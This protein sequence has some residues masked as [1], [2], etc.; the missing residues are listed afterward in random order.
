MILGNIPRRPGEWTV[1]TLAAY[2]LELEEALRHALSHIEADN[3][4]DGAVGMNQLSP[5]IQAKLKK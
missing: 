2:V 1:E 5:D 4:Q 3:I